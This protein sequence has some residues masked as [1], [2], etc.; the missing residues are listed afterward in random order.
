MY[1]QPMPSSP[2]ARARPLLLALLLAACVEPRVQPAPTAS[3]RGMPTA[4]SSPLFPTPAFTSAPTA[5][6]TLAPTAAPI[7]YIVES[8][9]TLIGIAVRHD[10]SLE[11]IESANIGID[12][13]NL[14][15]GQSIVI[16]APTAAGVVGSFIPVSTPLPVNMG[17]FNCVPTP[18]A[19]TICLGEFINSTNESILNLAVQVTLLDASGQP[20]AEAI[21]NSPL[22]LIPPGAAVPLAAV[23]PGAYGPAAV[24]ATLAAES[25][26]GLADRFVTLGIEGASGAASPSGYIIDGRLVNPTAS[27]IR[28]IAVIGTVYNAAGGVIGYRELSVG[29][30]LSARA[31][32]LF[33][34]VLPGVQDAAQ[35][36]VI[37]QGRMP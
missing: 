30:S 12:P 32:S 17:V 36:A 16:P 11:A 18:A 9:D 33:S 28:S 35:W 4:T 10:V 2:H 7:T 8:G 15:P 21:A 29:E 34:I 5:F 27:E 6:P 37:A 20:A 25:G 3:L 31:S 19:S 1:N 23:F 14:Q 13:G 24:G 22:D 26:A